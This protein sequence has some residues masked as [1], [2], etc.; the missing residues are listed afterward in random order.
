MIPLAPYEYFA[1]VASMLLWRNPD[2]RRLVAVRRALTRHPLKTLSRASRQALPQ[3]PL[4]RVSTGN[5]GNNFESCPLV[6][7]P[8][9]SLEPDSF[10]FRRSLSTLCLYKLLPLRHWPPYSLPRPV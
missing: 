9:L 5:P 7:P 2:R 6:Y 10:H 4:A 1:G 8:I 3:K